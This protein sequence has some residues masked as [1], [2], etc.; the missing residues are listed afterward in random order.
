MNSLL[1]SLLFATALTG[2]G[3]SATPSTAQTPPSGR[4]VVVFVADGLRGGSVD[5]KVTP[6]F[7]HIK[8]DGV[9]FRNSHSIFP[10]FTTAN[11]SAMATGH[12]LGD[13]GDFSNTIFTGYPGPFSNGTVTPFIE[14]DQN[15]GDIDDHFLGTVTGPDGTAINVG[16]LDEETILAAARAAGYHTA[17]VGKLG[18]V[19]IFDHN[20]SALVQEATRDA[21]G[22]PTIIVDD[23]TGSAS[24]IPLDP[25]LVAALAAAGVPTTAPSRGANGSAGTNVTPGTLLPNLVQQ[26]FF[27]QATSDVILP[28]FKQDGRPFVMV[29]WSRDPDGT[30]HNQGDSLN[31]LVPG[32][33][34]PTSQS[35][36]ANA[37]DD[38]ARL[39]DALDRLGLSDNT[40]IIVTA[41]HG[42]STISKNSGP[43]SSQ[44]S[45][46]YAATQTYQTYR[47]INGVTQLAQEV[48]TGYLPSGF[49]AIDVAHALGAP[50]FDPDSAPASA[51][52]P[53]APSSYPSVDPTQAP[54]ADGSRRQ[55]PANGNGVIGH[56]PNNPDVVVAANGGSD[57]IYLPNSA[58][59]QAVAQQIIPFLEQQDYVSGVFVD[60]ALGSFSGTLPLSAINLQGKAIT[61]VP[62]IVVNFASRSTLGQGCSA[63][64][65]EQCGVEIADTGLQQGQGMHGNFSRADTFNFMAAFGPDF[66]EGFEDPAPASN[67]D[68]GKTVAHILGLDL[69]SN[70]T[71]TG[72]VLSEAFENHDVPDFRT[73][74]LRSL[75]GVDGVRTV[76]KM[77][78][79]GGTKYFDAAGFPGRTLGLK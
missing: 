22:T 75:P 52:R 15:L 11:A 59:A 37:D 65:A 24:G 29:F 73:S 42:F 61:P 25:A 32:I 56:D 34:G 39:M 74:Y 13:T 64:I 71:L 68:I 70:G 5:H 20:N 45:T 9:W 44:S 53:V 1:H 47:A 36:V 19:A 78:S 51:P 49:L 35:A 23:A 67:A 38:L 76:I 46:S 2:V 77:Q 43:D 57:L 30:Q 41:D 16:Y 8:S 33:N 50:L 12:Y 17:S 60:D 66:K 62:T 72:R 27:V 10:T 6:A 55:R 79:V 54:A 69:A 18:P 26:D 31:Q 3:L 4:N 58:S 21:R 28:L 48:P 63:A 14:N 7:D 40:D